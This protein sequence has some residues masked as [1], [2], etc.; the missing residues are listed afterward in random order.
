[1]AASNQVEINVSVRKT[2]KHNSR[3]LRKEKKIPAIVYGPKVKNTTIYLHENDAVKYS[4]HGFENAIFTLKS[5]ESSINNVKVLKKALAI[6]PVSRRPIHLDF[7]APDMTKNVRVAV[8]IRFE[9]KPIGLADGGL[10]TINRRDVEVECLPTAIP[11]FLPINVSNLGLNDG[12]HVS[13]L[14]APDGIKIITGLQESLVTVTKPEE[15]VAIPTAA[16][17]AAPAEGAAAAPAAGADAKAAAKP[18]AAKP[19]AGGDKKK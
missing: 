15:E 5:D 4:R 10:L 14:N 16:A 11:A 2:G 17:A 6:H 9:G 8:E 13:D 1:M 19:A 12:L 3:G 18:A 7:F